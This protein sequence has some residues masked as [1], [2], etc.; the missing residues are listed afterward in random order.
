[1]L[2]IRTTYPEFAELLD[3][4]RG[5]R[6]PIA[7]NRLSTIWQKDGNELRSLVTRM[8]DAA[9]LQEHLHS[10]DTTMPRYAVAELYLYGLGMKRQGQ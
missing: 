8:I 7:L 10:A 6:S 4:L 9:I 1:V 2:E 3:R 5:E